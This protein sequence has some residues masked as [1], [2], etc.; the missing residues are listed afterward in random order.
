MTKEDL[1][2][3]ASLAS[4]V[5]SGGGDVLIKFITSREQTVTNKIGDLGL[6]ENGDLWMKRR[7]PGGSLASAWTLKPERV[8]EIIHLGVK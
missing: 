8:V 7:L 1:I 3:E 2:T 6:T 4:L 5:I